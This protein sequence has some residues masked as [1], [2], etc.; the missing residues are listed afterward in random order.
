MGYNPARTWVGFATKNQGDLAVAGYES[1]WGRVHRLSD[2]STATFVCKNWRLGAGLGGGSSLHMV[3]FLNVGSALGNI[4]GKSLGD[5][6]SLSCSIPAG[7][8]AK[9]A[10]ELQDIGKIVELYQIYDMISTMRDFAITLYDNIKGQSATVVTKEVGSLAL[11]AGLMRSFGGT[12]D[13]RHV[14]FA[15]GGYIDNL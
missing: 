4:E 8:M 5:G 11:S 10:D 15:S 14:K 7:R 3:A 1:Y 9:L 12:I 2:F 6:W 13:I